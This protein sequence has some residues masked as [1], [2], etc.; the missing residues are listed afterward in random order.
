HRDCGPCH[1]RHRSSRGWRGRATGDLKSTARGSRSPRRASPGV[2]ATSPGSPPLLRRPGHN[3]LNVLTADTIGI[4]GETGH[5]PIEH[6]TQGGLTLPPRD[7]FTDRAPEGG[8]CRIIS[9]G[10]QACSVSRQGRRVL[11]VL[12]DEDAGEQR[13]LFAGVAHTLP[14]NPTNHRSHDV[15]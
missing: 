11:T 7:G 3:R 6:L 9:F 13:N 4:H 5:D 12:V 14:T 10:P 8:S 1:G 15:P 2:T